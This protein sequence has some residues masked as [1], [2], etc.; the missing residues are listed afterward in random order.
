MNPSGGKT[1]QYH[2]IATN[3]KRSNKLPTYAQKR[4]NQNLLKL[5]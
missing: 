3:G 4:F 1:V 5:V 2:P